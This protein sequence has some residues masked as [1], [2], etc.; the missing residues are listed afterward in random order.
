[1]LSRAG[2]PNGG[3]TNVLCNIQCG[4]AYSTSHIVNQHCIFRLQCAAN[5]KGLPCG[6]VVHGD[7]CS[8][9]VGEPAWFLEDLVERNNYLGGMAAKPGQSH[10]RLTQPLFFD[11]VANGVDHT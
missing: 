4:K 3:G 9:R 1:M 7:S 8:L 6:Q 11:T 5:N 10:Y 2:C